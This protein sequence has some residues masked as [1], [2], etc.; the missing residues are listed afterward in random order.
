G[1]QPRD[2]GVTPEPHAL[3]AR[4]RTRTLRRRLERLLEGAVSGHVVEQLLVAEGL[5]SGGRH[6]GFKGHGLVDEPVVD[7]GPQ[8]GVDAAGEGGPRHPDAGE[9]R[10]SVV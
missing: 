10:K 5:A 9:D 1:A 8:P 7:L 6:P 2:A 3:A 4:E